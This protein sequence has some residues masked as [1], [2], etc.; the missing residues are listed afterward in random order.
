MRVINNT[1]PDHRGSLTCLDIKIWNQLNISKNIKKFT[2]RGMH[3]QDNPR[4]EKLI[5]VTSGK[6]VDFIYDLDTKELECFVLNETESVYVHEN[7][8]H[9]FITLEDDTTVVY[10]VNGEYNPS[11]E[12]S[13]VW[14]TIPELESYI[15][16]ICSKEDIIISDKDAEGK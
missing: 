15:K 13:I 7:A 10:C 9:G 5:T 16:T 14:D 12:K 8:A 11:E 1:F 2:L 4:Q 6:I 3:Y